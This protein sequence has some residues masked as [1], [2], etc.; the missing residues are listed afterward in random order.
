MKPTKLIFSGLNSFTS[1]QVVDF[2]QLSGGMFGIFG[3]TGSGKT[4]IL[5]AIM[6]ALFGQISK[7]AKPLD[8]INSKS[9]SAFVCLEF[10]CLY[11]G[12]QKKFFVQR[13]YKKSKDNLLKS[14]IFGEMISSQRKIIAN[15]IRDVD[16]C[17]KDVVGLSFNEFSK[18]IALPQGE[19]ASFLNAT[20][21]ERTEII[22]NIFSLH[23][24]G[25]KLLDKVKAKKNQLETQVNVFLAQRE[26]LEKVSD[27]ELKKLGEELEKIKEE[28]KE[29]EREKAKKSARFAEIKEVLTLQKR[30]DELSQEW[31]E[32][33]KQKPLFKEKELML[34]KYVRANTI[35]PD[36]EK[37]KILKLETKNLKEKTSILLSDKVESENAYNSYVSSEE[38]FEREFPWRAVELSRKEN[39][40]T[41]AVENQ[42]MVVSYTLEKE[43]LE[44]KQQEQNQYIEELNDKEQKIS[45]Q[46]AS[47]NENIASIKSVIENLNQDKQTIESIEKLSLK[48]QEIEVYEAIEKQVENLIDSNKEKGESLKSQYEKI[49]ATYKNIDENLKKLNS[50]AS[51]ILETNLSENLKNL[52]SVGQK[53]SLIQQADN[54]IVFINKLIAQKQN[55]KFTI[56]DNLKEL[57][58][59]KVKLQNEHKYNIETLSERKNEVSLRQEEYIALS[60]SHLGNNFAGK[61]GAILVENNF[62]LA[63][64]QKEIKIAKESEKVAQKVYENSLIAEHNNV[65]EM[66]NK[67]NELGKIQQ[68]IDELEKMKKDIYFGFVDRNNK[69]LDNY[70]D[71]K[72]LLKIQLDRLEKLFSDEENFRLEII[73]KKM[74]LIEFGTRISAQNQYNDELLELLHNL[75]KYRG[76]CQFEIFGM[77]DRLGEILKVDEKNDIS[78]LISQKNKELSDCQDGLVDLIT[79]NANNQNEKSQCV[80]SIKNLE[81][82]ISNINNMIEEKNSQIL[83]VVKEGKLASSMLEEI[84]QEIRDNSEHFAFLTQKK[85]KL[86]EA[87]DRAS[88]EY[89]INQTLLDQKANELSDLEFNFKTTLFDLGFKSEE[90]AQKYLLDKNQLLQKQEE[91]KDYKNSLE[92]LQK[93]I[94]EVLQRLDGRNEQFQDLETLERENFDLSTQLGEKQIELGIKSNQFEK[95]QKD[96]KIAKDIDKKLPILTQKLDDAKELIN[97]LRGQALVQ[98]IAEEYMQEITQ[99]ASSKLEMI[100]GGRFELCYENKDFV[101]YDN[102]MGRKPRIVQTLSGGETFLVSLSLALAISEIISMSQNKSMEFFFLDEGFGTLDSELVESVVMALYKL[103]SHNFKIGLISHVKE[104]EEQM[105]N[106]IIVSGATDNQ[107]SSLKIVHNL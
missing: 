83:A 29:L 42:R 11:E 101:V 80:L 60:K 88:N 48:Q 87:F 18:C 104:L 23:E 93:Q 15:G 79:Q 73:Q 99:N 55:H 97:V 76:E 10:E 91:I 40:L 45:E 16:Q 71:L 67:E 89:K 62:D 49:F 47:L 37:L 32:K 74:Q 72:S 107:G 75:Q 8:F 19:F 68:E 103:E 3:K 41:T 33:I 86:K 100:M 12:V 26:M 64:A 17:I 7:N 65:F 22:C 69:M 50:S 59:Q 31:E 5:D 38:K 6:L 96:A 20:L 102:L 94:E 90:D 14:A 105:K 66:K 57:E 61:N 70:S 77:K 51:Q 9:Q 39:E 28:T 1:E 78:S 2:D 54:Q 13:E 25:E 30:L 82:K 53:Y 92:I 24:Y 36:L 81:E 44:E 84:K 4:T 34:E 56:L 106:K 58:S 95:L 27:E 52:L 35:A 21:A 43:S 85:Q 98:Y 63:S 46:I